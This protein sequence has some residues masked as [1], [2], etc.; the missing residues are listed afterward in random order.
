MQ[1]LFTACSVVAMLGAFFALTR[2]TRYADLAQEA[3]N[4]TELFVTKLRGEIARIDATEHRC[5]QNAAKLKSLE[6]KFYQSRRTEDADASAER[7]FNRTDIPKNVL[8][9]LGSCDNWTKALL[10]GPRSEAASCECAYCVGMRTQRRAEKAAIL[11]SRPKP[12][13][14]GE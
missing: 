4:R 5:E 12:V 3:Q 6:G 8:P 11:A 7:Y 1:I 14:G 9:V 10:E 2:A 13:L